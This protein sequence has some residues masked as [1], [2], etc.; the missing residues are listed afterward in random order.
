MQPRGTLGEEPQGEQQEAGCG[1]YRQDRA[2]DSEKCGKDPESC[3][4]DAHGPGV[5]FLMSGHECWDGL[6][7][8][9]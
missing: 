3:V 9:I 4:H 6:A 5:V 2:D 8:H 1:H 7:V